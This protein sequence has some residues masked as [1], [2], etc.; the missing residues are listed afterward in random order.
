MRRAFTL[1]ELLV[2]IAIIA[3]LAAILFPVFA[4][5]KEAAKATAD[6]SNV[7]QIVIAEQIYA[8]DSDDLCPL[9]HGQV[10]ATGQHVFNLPKFVPADWAQAPSG[11][12]AVR[13]EGSTTFFMNSMQPYIKNYQ[14]L[15]AP[16]VI[17]YTYSGGPSN[18]GTAVLAAGKQ[19]KATTYAYNGFL[20]GYSGTA[21]ADPAQL[22]MLTGLHGAMEKLGW[23]RSNPQLWCVTNGGTCVY[24][25]WKS[26]CAVTDNGAQGSAYLAAGN[27]NDT[28]PAIAGQ[29]FFK[30]GQ[31]WGFAD[32]HA[33]FRKVGATIGAEGTGPHTDYRTDPLTWYFPDGKA[34]YYWWDG[35]HAWLFRP[36]YDFSQ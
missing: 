3:I 18:P 26:G 20:H 25:P 19:K 29:W 8:T 34:R 11:E 1:I 12:D 6:L 16:S 4:Q 30:K 7:K 31:N 9:S 21:I 28:Y 24:Q 10:A 15:A 22:P 33:K 35:C 17:K 13:Y 5:A 32:S 2:V 27:Q 14:M 23:G 36:D